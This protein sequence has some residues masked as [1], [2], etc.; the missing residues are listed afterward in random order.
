MKIEMGESLVRT[1]VRHCRGCQL[2]ELNWKPSPVWAG[3]ATGEQVGWYEAAK[4]VFHSAVLKKTAGLSQFLRQAE[5]DV[6]G[7][8]TEGIEIVNIIGVDIA[9]HTQ[10][11]LYISNADTGAIIAKKMF[12]TA[13]ILDTYFPGVP[14]E[15][16]FLSP[17]VNPSTVP[18]VVEAQ[19]MMSAFFEEKRPSFVFQTIING[20]FKT[21]ILDAAS[22][23]AGKVADTSELFL[24]AMQLTN[25]FK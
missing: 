11:L 7:V 24:R 4:E 2:A 23:C 8:R 21:R 17:K 15:I 9:V 20:D 6:L 1:W 12:R 5:L 3:E 22:K 18:F 13:L 14:A 10:G 25:L 16:L 19:E